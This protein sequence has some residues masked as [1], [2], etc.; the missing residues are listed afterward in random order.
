MLE[1]EPQHEGF[2]REDNFRSLKDH[3]PSKF[4]VERLN[5]KF[6]AISKEL[7]EVDFEIEEKEAPE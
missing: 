5:G 4:Y 2:L 6:T 7:K 3:G 1:H